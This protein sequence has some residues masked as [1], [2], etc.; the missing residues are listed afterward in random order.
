MDFAVF[1]DHRIK[2]KESD[3]IN[4]FLDFAKELKEYGT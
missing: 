2:I 3:K 4:R 1:A